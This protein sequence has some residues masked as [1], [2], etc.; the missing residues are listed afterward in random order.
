MGYDPEEEKV[1][2]DLKYHKYIEKS[3]GRRC[4]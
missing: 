4:F 1:A 2:W 3:I